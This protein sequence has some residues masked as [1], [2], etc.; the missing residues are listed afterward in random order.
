MREA[1]FTARRANAWDARYP[2]FILYVPIL[3]TQMMAIRSKPP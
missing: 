1:P 2:L 3:I